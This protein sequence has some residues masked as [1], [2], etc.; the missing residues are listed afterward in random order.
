MCVV[1]D[2]GMLFCW[3][4]NAMGQLGLM[5]TKEVDRATRVLFT[6]P[7]LKSIHRVSLG[8]EDTCIANSLDAMVFCF[9][10]NL[11]SGSNSPLP[12]DYPL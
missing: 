5:S 10:K 3:G 11:F 12:L 7:R 6:D 2:D 4:S 9:G 8:D 1:D